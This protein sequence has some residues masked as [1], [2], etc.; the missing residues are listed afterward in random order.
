MQFE[1][2]AWTHAKAY[3][4]SKLLGIM[5]T[6]GFHFSGK[7]PPTT[8]MLTFHPGAINTKM[9]LSAFGK[10]G[11][12]I[13]KSTDTFN[14]ATCPSFTNPGALP[15]YYSALKESKPAKQATDEAACRSVFEFL[16]KEIEKE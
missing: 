6:N 1:K 15:K 2:G 10:V 4:L 14:L 11:M 16:E 3:A 5:W 8:T 13:E 9:L 12:D 7:L